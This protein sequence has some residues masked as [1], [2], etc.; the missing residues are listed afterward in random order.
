MP[1]GWPFLVLV[2]LQAAAV[3][4][5]R[6]PGALRRIARHPLVGLLPLVGIGGTVVALGAWP[7]AIDAVTA[8][9]AVAVP[10]LALAAAWHVRRWVVPL[11]ASSPLLWVIAWRLR[12]GPVADLAGDVLIV[13]AAAML[14]RLT[15]WVAPRWALA[16][17]VLLATGVDI[18]QVWQIEVQPVAQALGVAVPPQGLPALQELRMGGATMG[19]GDAYIAA[20][21]GAVVA[22]SG[23]AT[24][25]AALGG[26]AGGALLGVLF[27][28]VDFVPA[29][30]P[31]ALG[32]LAAGGVERR[33]VSRWLRAA[34][35]SRRRPRMQPDKEA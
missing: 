8:L 4:A 6:D 33:A 26:A 35:D 29:T 21:V 3:A 27:L 7:G 5:V 2:L 12:P 32:L 17:G 22:V 9:A 23:R 13:L 18:W 19:W 28:W 11:A 14:G 10:L 30:V 20:L 34:A 25:A 24:I 31:A 15:G 16:G 1:Y